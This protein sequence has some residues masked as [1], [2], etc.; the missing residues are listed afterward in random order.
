MTDRDMEPFERRFAD[1]VHA[2][3]DPA[4]E[5]RIDALVVS[6]TAMS[7]Q[8]GPGWLQRRLG[9]GLPGRGITGAR[10]AVAFVGVAQLAS[11]REEAMAR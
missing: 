6:R 10:W 7:S 4:T 5:R 9:V 8:H 3:T 2:Y 11:R 1:R